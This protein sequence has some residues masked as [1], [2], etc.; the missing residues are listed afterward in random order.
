MR[1]LLLLFLATAPA[2]AAQTIINV[3]PQ[4]CVWHA[5]DDSAWAARDLDETGW[6][7]LAQWK[8]PDH[9]HYW[10]RCHADLSLLRALVHPALTV[11]HN[12]AYQLYLDGTLV[13]TSGNP[14]TGFSYL[15]S[16]QIFPFEG[17]E[18]DG[19]RDVAGG[20]STIAIRSFLRIP[21]LAL[22]DPTLHILAGDDQSLREHLDSMALSGEANWIATAIGFGIIG[23]AGFIFF[24]LYCFDR[25][26]REL[27]ILSFI[28][29]GLSGERIEQTLL[30]AHVSLGASVL[31]FLL[32]VELVWTHLTAICAYWLNHRRVPLFFK[33]VTSLCMAYLLLGFCSLLL[34]FNAAYGFDLTRLH[35]GFFYGTCSCILSSS[36]VAAFLP[37]RTVA[38]PRRSLAICCLLWGTGDLI[39]LVPRALAYLSSWARTLESQ[40]EPRLLEVRSISIITVVVALVV[41][42]FRDQQRT[43]RERAEL[44]G[45]M[46]AA[47]A[48]QQVIVPAAIPSV[49]G[50]NL[51]GVYKPAGEVGGDFFQII[52]TAAGGVLAVIGDVS[53]KG[54]PAA[55]TVSL[56]VGTFRT[57]AHYTQSPGEILRAM[58]QRMLGRNH[59]GFTT[60]LVMRAET[61]GKLIVANAGHL[62]P[63]F[64][65]QELAI[66]NGLPLGLA[67]DTNY[68][69]SAFELAPGGALTLLTDG[70]VEARN[71]A[72]ELFGF[73]RTQAISGQSAESIAQAAQGFGQDDDITVLTI[74]LIPAPDPIPV[75]STEPAPSRA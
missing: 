62:A 54:M 36:L 41:L 56:L 61:G 5:G 30:A 72:G 37:W 51:E 4:Q 52:A 38:P 66:E 16:F 40:I 39:Y 3:P 47:R 58:N 60:C 19:A 46:Q 28:C 75:P 55:M 63:Y 67:A 44:A 57:L 43:A 21:A 59:G 27:L 14:A 31:F 34:P 2:L 42:M 33:I 20:T 68:T 13:G 12:T 53:G 73:E 24:G 71:P 9:P 50:F 48:V 18:I 69:E 22:P 6:Q 49:P 32:L 35:S 25:S 45:E 11:Y 10:I 26:R 70:V 7:P 1:K 65:G 23:A 74:A 29:W 64:N 17:S 8:L 15:Y